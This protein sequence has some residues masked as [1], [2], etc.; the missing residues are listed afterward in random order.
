MNQNFFHAKKNQ[1]L[2]FFVDAQKFYRKALQEDPVNSHIWCCYGDMLRSLGKL[3][4]AEQCYIRAVA[5]DKKNGYAISKL[6]FTKRAIFEYGSQDFSQQLRDSFASGSI[7][8]P[9]EIFPSAEFSAEWHGKVAQRWAKS[10]KYDAYP[11]LTRQNLPYENK[12]LKI[13]YVSADWM[14]HATLYLL[15]EVLFRHNLSVC[16]IHIFAIGKFLDEKVLKNLQRHGLQV[17]ILNNYDDYAAAQYISKINIDVLIDLKGYTSQARPGIF[18]YRPCQVQVNWLGFP[19]S[20]GCSNLCDYIIADAVVIPL[21]QYDYYSEKIISLPVPYQ[22]NSRLKKVR[23]DSKSPFNEGVFVFCSFS[24]IYKYNTETLAAWSEILALAPESVL[25]LLDGPECAKNNIYSF[26][27]AKGVDRDRIVFAENVEQT[28]HLDRLNH[29]HLMLDTWPVSGHTTASDALTQ[30]VPVLTKMGEHFVSRVAASLLLHLGLP[31]L[32]VKTYDQYINLAVSLAKDTKKY[33][34]I[35]STLI[36]RKNKAIWFG[37]GCFVKILEGLFRALVIKKNHPKNHIVIFQEQELI[38]AAKELVSASDYLKAEEIATKYVNSN[39]VS[40]EGLNLLAVIYIHQKRYDEALNLL[41]TSVGVSW[42]KQATYNIAVVLNRMGK[43]TESEQ[44]SMEIISRGFLDHL[45]CN[46]LGL[47]IQNQGRLSEAIEWYRKSLAYLPEYVEARFNLVAALNR[48]CQYDA[49]LEL[50]YSTQPAIGKKPAWINEEAIAASGK[51]NFIKA[52]DLYKQAL[53]IDQNN[54]ECRVNMA[55]CLAKAGMLSE[56]LSEYLTM[57]E[58]YPLNYVVWD[59]FLFAL[60]YCAELSMGQKL[61]YYN[62]YNKIFKKTQGDFFGGDIV[63]NGR[64]RVGYVYSEFKK[65]SSSN[66]LLPLI[67]GH[68]P[69]KFEIYAYA[70]NCCFDEI[71]EAYKNAVDVWRETSGM[72]N[73]ELFNIIRKDNINILVDIAGHVGGNRLPVFAMKPSPVS[74]HWLDFGCTTGLSAIDYYLADEKIAPAGSDNHFVEKIVRLSRLSLVYRATSGMGEV[75]SPPVLKNKYI[76]FGSL[77]R[78]IRLNSHVI[79]A[80]SRILKSVPDSKLVINSRNFSSEEMQELLVE[81]F[82]KN[83]INRNRLEIGFDSP[84]WDLLRSID[85]V[86]DCFPHSSGTTLIE[87]LYMGVPYITLKDSPP[88]GTLGAALLETVGLGKLVSKNIDDYVNKAVGLSGNLKYLE[89]IRNNLRSAMLS[90]ELMDEAGFVKEVE[91]CY[92]QMWANRCA[93]E[94]N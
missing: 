60:N 22:P 36:D 84:P 20:L 82:S 93:Y 13:G 21:E 87:S 19:G 74:F 1:E 66:F 31:E 39:P 27:D 17:H 68:S 54:F 33:Q 18:A 58:K 67:E 10:F 8:T 56:S 35:K 92:E 6:F 4:D 38:S 45:I 34:C 3:Q 29:A 89:S 49:A 28:A 90:S 16:E 32:V 77:S 72:S 75:G 9:F 63:N 26:F 71:S 91:S 64:I 78:A 86:L 48:E 57:L 65:H 46:V 51:Q 42:N 12:T 44:V 69:Q 11:N 24:Q 30:D 70:D 14:E 40:Q 79:G 37:A 53:L 5:S 2:G 88:I 73:D 61:A 15:K 55:S 25:W 41:L 85:I 80:W 7:L 43:Y 94:S 52:I 59:N 50:I 76:T 47:S 83:G 23:L 81:Q 62:Q